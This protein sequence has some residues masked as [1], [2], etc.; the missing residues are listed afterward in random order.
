MDTSKNYRSVKVKV[1]E[2]P[3]L[4]SVE[5]VLVFIDVWISTLI[6]ELK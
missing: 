2:A 1:C 6:S 4:I 3:N 5:L